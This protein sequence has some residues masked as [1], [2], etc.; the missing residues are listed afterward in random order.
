[1]A[2]AQSNLGG[3]YANGHGVRQDNR[4]AKYYF[5]LGCD[6]GNQLGCDNYRILNRGR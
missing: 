5:G 2:E 4:K 6:N 1:M 3:M